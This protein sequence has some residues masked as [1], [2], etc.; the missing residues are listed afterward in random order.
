MD[1][2]SD[3]EKGFILTGTPGTGKSIFLFYLLWQL[4]SQRIETVILRRDEDVG[5]IYIFTK[6]GCFVTKDADEIDHL[7]DKQTTWYLT[8]TLNPQPQRAE[9]ITILV[10]SP[11]REHYKYFAKLH[12]SVPIHHLPPWTLDELLAAGPSYGL[13][14]KVI[15]KRFDIVGGVPRAVFVKEKV[16]ID[17]I[18]SDIMRAFSYFKHENI[19]NINSQ[20]LLYSPEVCHRIIHIFVWLDMDKDKKYVNTF[21]DF[22]STFVR[23][24]AFDQYITYTHQKLAASLILNQAVPEAG[25]LQGFHFELYAHRRLL[26]GGSFKYRSLDVENSSVQTLHVP[27]QKK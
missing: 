8:D 14:N 5:R 11:N 13:S 4:A 16:G 10:S 15:S 23:E 24:Y 1:Y 18:K 27:V 9:A 12:P 17:Q 19:P 22:A 7:L 6:D 20:Q 25:S 3:G 21:S 2:V 26:E